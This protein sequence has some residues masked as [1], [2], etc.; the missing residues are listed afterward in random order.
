MDICQIER[1][2]ST[3]IN[4]SALSEK[5]ATLHLKYQDLNLAKT[6]KI[7]KDMGTTSE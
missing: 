1:V 6:D 4:F 7:F 2:K 3:R 5:A